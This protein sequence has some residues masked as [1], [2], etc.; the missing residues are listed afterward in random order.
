MSDE[1]GVTLTTKGLDKLIK[2]LKIEEMPKARVGILGR[3]A[4]SGTGGTNAE[5]GAAHEFGAP[6]RGLPIRSWLRIPLMDNLAKYLQKNGAL[7][8][9]TLN[10]VIKSGTV[11][12]WLK[13]IAIVAEV[14]IQDAFNSG[15]FG[16]WAPWK[17]PGYNNNAGQIL[18]DTQQLRNSVTSEV[19]L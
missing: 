7:D 2:A 11:T 18:V 9:R 1:P 5:V 6:A 8:Q 15:G 12:P 19:S 4:R 16:K 17:T 3:N 14:I 13:K 10:E